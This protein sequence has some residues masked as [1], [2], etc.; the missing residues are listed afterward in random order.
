LPEAE[1]TAAPTLNFE[2]GAYAR[3]RTSRAFLKSVIKFLDPH[4]ETNF[5]FWQANGENKKLA[6]G[7]LNNNYIKKPFHNRV[8]RNFK[9]QTN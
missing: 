7:G 1:R 2:Y 9:N 3:S 4:F 5:Y 6:T 8:P